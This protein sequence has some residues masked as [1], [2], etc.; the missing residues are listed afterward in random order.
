M[1]KLSLLIALIL[2]VTIGGVYATW[3]Y[4]TTT[5]AG[6]EFTEYASITA[7]ANNTKKGSMTLTTEPM[8]IIDDTNADWVAEPTITNP[9]IRFDPAQSSEV[10]AIKMKCVITITPGSYNDNDGDTDNVDRAILSAIANPVDV[11]GVTA[12]VYGNVITLTTNTAVD[13]WTIDLSK[14]IQLNEGQELLL[15]YLTDYERFADVLKNA[16]IKLVYS[17]VE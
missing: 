5:S 13:T 9:V 14:Y 12:V 6:L 10:T 1:K 11:D 2:C 17:E 3:S 7:V 8:Y 4:A 15:P 16:T